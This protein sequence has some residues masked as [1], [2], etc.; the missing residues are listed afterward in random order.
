MSES[1]GSIRIPMSQAMK[2]LS[3]EVRVTGVR[4]WAFRMWCALRLL[5]VA[6]WLVGGKWTIEVEP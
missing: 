2:N 5:H 1:I 6:K 3:V 4:A